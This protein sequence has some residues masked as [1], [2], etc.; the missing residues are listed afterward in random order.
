MWAII[1]AGIFDQ[2]RGFFYTGNA[3]QLGIQLIGAF[4]YSLWA[5]LL[6][7]LFFY[8]LKKN[9]RLRVNIIYEIIGLDFIKH[10]TDGQM[11]MLNLEEE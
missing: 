5:A 9:G 4:A 7:F 10:Q 8:A 3:H 6:S 2:E 1:A 11:Y